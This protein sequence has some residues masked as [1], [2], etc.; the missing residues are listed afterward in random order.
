MA[1]IKDLPIEQRPREKLLLKGPSVLTD[2]ELLAILLRLGTKGKSAV[3]VG[4]EIIKKY[5]GYKGIAGRSF[6]EFRQI[7]GL[8]NA[9]IAQL[10]AA[11]EIAGRIVKQLK[12]EGDL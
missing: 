4:Q 6:E 8:S 5:G 7:K 9:K 12:K 11:F 1:K 10:A 3:E 2:A